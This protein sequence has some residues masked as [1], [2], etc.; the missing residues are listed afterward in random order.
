MSN[1]ILLICAL[2]T[3]GFVGCVGIPQESYSDRYEPQAQLPPERPVTLCRTGL[4][5][6]DSVAEERPAR[7]SPARLHFAAC[8]KCRE[9]LKSWGGE[10]QQLAKPPTSD[11][12]IRE[13]EVN[14]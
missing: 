1:I 2:C 8:T 11:G 7:P 13:P 10:W 9:V 12:D 14:P 3:V 5:L 6:W 4:E